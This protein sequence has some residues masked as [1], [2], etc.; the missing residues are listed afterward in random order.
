MLFRRRTKWPEPMSLRVETGLAV[1]CC[2]QR[3]IQTV[4]ALHGRAGDEW[5]FTFFASRS[6]KPSDCSVWMK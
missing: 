3:V 1:F 6:G 5:K 4:G 2:E